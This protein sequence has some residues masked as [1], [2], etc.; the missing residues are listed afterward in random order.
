MKSE[1][2]FAVFALLT[3]STLANPVQPA[4]HQFPF[5][6][7]LLSG[8][9]RCSG[10]LISRRAILTVNDCLT[11]ATTE[12]ILGANNIA[13]HSEPTQIRFTVGESFYRRDTASPLAVVRFEPQIAFLTDSVNII[14]LPFSTPNDVFSDMSATNLG[15]LHDATTPD[16]LRSWSVNTIR[17]SDCTR[18]HPG[19]TSEQICIANTSGCTL[20]LG[21][22]IV[23][24]SAGRLSQ[25][26]IQFRRNACGGGN[27]ARSIFL[28]VTP[29]LTFI[30]TH[31]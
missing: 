15:F 9:T 8:V 14:Q 1:F 18:A 27:N 4:T 12:V 5:A 30:R 10:S 2:V 19:V 3:A 20:S 16:T 31:M 11:S 29:F 28:R 22:P 26:A 25:I 17:N 7:G 23:A 21:Q 24:N 6:V 13:D